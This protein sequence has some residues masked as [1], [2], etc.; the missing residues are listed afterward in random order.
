[1]GR[2]RSRRSAGAP[3]LRRAVADLRAL[4]HPLRLRMIEL[5]AESP[6]TTKQVAEIL[7]QPPTRLYHH[8]AALERSGLLVLKERRKNRGTVE[9]WYAGVAQQIRAEGS[10]R[11]AAAGR[12][13]RRAVAATV[14]EQTKQELV[15]MPPH[16]REAALLGRLVL[17]LPSSQVPVIRKLL[18]DTVRKLGAKFRSE[19]EKDCE[20]WA[21]TVAFAPVTPRPE[22][23]RRAR[24]PRPGR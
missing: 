16:A 19:G 12:R 6:K 24:R 3:M 2:A 14:L 10:P 20:R 8:V 11:D 23:T 4:A 18:Y 9:K 22:S 1:M 5:F 21:V 13:V 17:G 7:G 15:T